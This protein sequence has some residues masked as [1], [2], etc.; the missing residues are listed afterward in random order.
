MSRGWNFRTS[1]RPTLAGSVLLVLLVPGILPTPGRP[2]GSGQMA[3]AAQKPGPPEKGK[4]DTA[5]TRIPP[6]LLSTGHRKLCRVYVGDHLP[7][8]ELPR[9]GGK[10]TDLASLQ[11]KRATVVLFWHPDRWMAQGAL[12]D[13]SGLA[14]QWVNQDVALVGIASS[15]PAGAIQAQLTAAK[16]TFPHLLDVDNQ[17]YA[18]VSSAV[19][20]T[21]LPRVYVLDAEGKIAWFDIEYSEATRRELRQTLKV[22]LKNP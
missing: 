16:A 2:A 21:A 6:V 14:R 15:Q 19:G 22:L 20:T 4:T 17:A 3:R 12:D 7:P 5:A 9:L 10:M 1:L 13:L 8:I 11:G 18:L